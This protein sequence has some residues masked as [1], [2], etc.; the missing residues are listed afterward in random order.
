MSNRR[1]TIIREENEELKEDHAVA[2]ARV[3]KLERDANHLTK[4]T[5]DLQDLVKIRS[6]RFTKSLEKLN[7]KKAAIKIKLNTKAKAE[8]VACTKISAQGGTI[9]KLEDLQTASKS[10][11]KAQGGTI[12]NLEHMQAASQSALK[13]QGGTIKKLEHLQVTSQ[14]ALKR[15]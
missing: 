14:S 11:L 2:E 13:A 9:K 7:E 15:K 1:N 3:K 12:N 10:A 4:Q 8:K 6:Q 5:T